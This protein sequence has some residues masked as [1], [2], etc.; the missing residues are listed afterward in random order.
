MAKYIFVTGGVVSSLGKGLASA[1]IGALL[2]A[3]GPQVT[4]NRGRGD[5]AP[6]TLLTLH[7]AKGLEFD[8][9]FLAGLEEGL[10]PHPRAIAFAEGLEEERRLCYVGMTR[11]MERLTMLHAT[12]RSLYGRTD[13]NLP[14]RFLDEIPHHLIDWRREEPVGR[15]PMSGGYGSAPSSMKQAAWTTGITT[16]GR[17]RAETRPRNVTRMLSRPRQRS[18]RNRAASVNGSPRCTLRRRSSPTSRHPV[19]WTWCG[20]GQRTS[21]RPG[22]RFE[23]WTPGH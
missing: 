15:S 12:R 23:R 17:S 10:F 1:S 22:G 11:A 14:S 13:M 8:H 5:G 4:S 9:V 18:A 19:K 7:S 3:L 16:D 21:A 20:A 6:V 2:E